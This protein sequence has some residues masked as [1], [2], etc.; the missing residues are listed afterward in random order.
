MQSGSQSDLVNLGHVIHIGQL[1]NSLKKA[2]VNP[3]ITEITRKQKETVLESQWL[4]QLLN[5]KV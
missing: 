5:L 1:K 4:F 2:R 3:R